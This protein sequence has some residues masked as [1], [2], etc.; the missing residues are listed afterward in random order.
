V[1]TV[2]GLKAFKLGAQVGTTSYQY[3][4]DQIKP[5]VEPNVYDTTDAAI[6][7][8]KAGQIKG[9]VADL[10]TVFY[11]R[12]GGQLDGGQIV[13][14]LPTAAGA[15]VEH[16]SILLDKGSSLTP[17]VNAALAA[18]KSDGTLAGIVDAWVTSQGAPELK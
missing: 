13:G 5:D 10:P 15:A 18:M 1:T 9:I 7:A 8:L 17:C 2:A 6:T 4:V 11:I 3:I 12:D 14:S 16:F